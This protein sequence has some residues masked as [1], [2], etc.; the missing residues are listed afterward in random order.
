VTAATLIS[1]IAADL[2][3]VTMRQ[4][5]PTYFRTSRNAIVLSDALRQLGIDTMSHIASGVAVSKALA[6]DRGCAGRIAA[7]EI[8][9]IK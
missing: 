2:A 9:T 1:A 5:S 7:P 8:L 3:H 6:V 4:R